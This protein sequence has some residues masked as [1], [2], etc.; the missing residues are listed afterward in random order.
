MVCRVGGRYIADLLA[1]MAGVHKPF[2]RVVGSVLPI[3]VCFD[4][5][6]CLLPGY[7][8]TDLSLVPVDVFFRNVAKESLLRSS[9]RARAWR[10]SVDRPRPPFSR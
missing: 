3:L 10:R 7:G 1:I 6:S 5:L 8:T 4:D 9:D 2:Y